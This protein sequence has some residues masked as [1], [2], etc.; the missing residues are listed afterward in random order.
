MTNFHGAPKKAHVVCTVRVKHSL[1]GSL[2]CIMFYIC[3]YRGCQ[4]LNKGYELNNVPFWICRITSIWI[5]KNEF[6]ISWIMKFV[7]SACLRSSIAESGHAGNTFNTFLLRLILAVHQFLT[8]RWFCDSHSI[9]EFDLQVLANENFIL[10]VI[11][12]C[13][14]FDF[15]S[16]GASPARRATERSPIPIETG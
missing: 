1:I 13:C 15:F 5:V 12:S 6:L 11:L 9:C 3:S 10:W 14:R 2:C 16:S 4:D 8:T 7:L